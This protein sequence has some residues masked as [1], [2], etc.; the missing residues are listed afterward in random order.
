MTPAEPRPPEAGGRTRSIL[1]VDMD[2]FFAAVEMR[3]DPDLR[4]RPVVVGADPR[5]GKGRG[6]VA[7]A[8]Y[9]ARE[10]GIHSA[11]PISEAY[12]R[13]PDAAYRRPRGDLYRRVSDRI[14]HVF[15][16][17]T[18][19]I[20]RLSIDEAFLDVTASQELFGSGEAMAREIRQEIRRRESLT[21]SV[22]VATSKFVAKVASDLDK[23][24]GLVV[25]PPGDEEEFVAPLSLEYLWGAGPRAR[26]RFRE[27][28]VETIGQV[29]ALDPSRLRR[30]FGEA[31][32]RRF[33]RLSRGID[34]RPVEPE[35]QRKSLGKEITF[36]QDISD[37]DRA[38]R[39]ILQLCE[40]VAR[41][42]RDRNLSGTTITIK[43]RWESFETVTRQTT[44]RRP[45]NTV[46]RIWP[47]ARSLFRRADPGSHRIRLVGVYV[48]GFETP[49]DE[50][51]GLFGGDDGGT[52]DR[53]VAGAVDRL[54]NR[55]GEDAVTRAALLRRHGPDGSGDPL[56]RNGPDGPGGCGDD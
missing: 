15:E 9:E 42:L 7:A 23:P 52:D 14:V 39:T 20:E 46:G 18:D 10:Y 56:S 48:S 37:R 13:C 31:A 6:V 12:R 45:V 1:H 32:A 16:E 43:V 29:A 2:A 19:R 51:L 47:A 17:Y 5:E 55:F 21:A 53:R 41:R 11:M 44:L 25:V 4:D 30:A 38:E 40:K 35:S 24:D 3:E 36:A 22:G 50:Q 54:A 26:E 34:P 28:G 33:H 8:S 49:E 27:L